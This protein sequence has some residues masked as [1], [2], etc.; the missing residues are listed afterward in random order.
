MTSIWTAIIHSRGNFKHDVVIA[1]KD[2]KEAYAVLSDRYPECDVVALVP[3]HHPD[4]KTFAVNKSIDLAV[5][6]FSSDN[7]PTR[8][9]D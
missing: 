8:G 5:D 6:D 1:P 4:V 7:T 3:G 2:T 9:S